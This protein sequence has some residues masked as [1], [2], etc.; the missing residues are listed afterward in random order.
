MN[1]KAIKTSIAAAALGLVLMGCA[2]MG[3][4]GG[5]DVLASGNHS[6]IKHQQ[7]TALH[8]QAAFDALWQKAFANLPAA[9][10]KPVIDF[11]KQMV[12]A[13]FIGQQSHGGY[14]VRI[15]HVDDS[16]PK[17]NVTVMVTIPGTNCR[18]PESPSDAYQFNALP[19]TTKPVRFH[20]RQQN[21]PGCG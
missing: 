17:L 1:I 13:S 14:L 7:Y 8:N 20:I 18:Y 16:G 19:A 2:S 12:I 4:S 21:A 6:N 3:G 11:S 9:P 10:N 15:G 5:T